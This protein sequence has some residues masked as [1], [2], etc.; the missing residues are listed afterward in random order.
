MVNQC[1]PRREHVGGGV[2][3]ELSF[4]AETSS[5]ASDD[6]SYASFQ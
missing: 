5:M 6:E 2:A 3:D 4:S 1:S